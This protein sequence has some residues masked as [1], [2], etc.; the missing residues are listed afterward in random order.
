MTKTNLKAN[1]IKIENLYKSMFS[2][3][4]NTSI[5]IEEDR[6]EI[7]HLDESNQ[8]PAIIDLQETEIGYV[9]NYWDGYSL[10]ESEE[11]VDLIQAL[12]IYKRYA[13][14]MA[15]NLKRFN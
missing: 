11:T 7:I 15:K 13:K 5:N 8:D 6:V 3:V 12:K 1:H 2:D 10:S 4:K 14:K 9:I